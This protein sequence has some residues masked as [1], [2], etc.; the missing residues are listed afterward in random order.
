MR[1][2]L[3]EGFS[4]HLL[5][6][7]HSDLY[8]YLEKIVH[9]RG[10]CFGSNNSTSSTQKSISSLPKD[11]SNSEIC[12]NGSLFGFPIPQIALLGYFPK[13]NWSNDEDYVAN[14]GKINYKDLGKVELW[15]NSSKLTW[16]ADESAN[17]LT[18]AVGKVHFCTDAL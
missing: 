13:Y 15:A 10:I 14:T 7:I 12:L 3:F 6:F 4:D 8:K 17:D 11:L 1:D 18:N 2:V 5:N 9:D 16:W